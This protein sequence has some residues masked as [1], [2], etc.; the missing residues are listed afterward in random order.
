MSSA[1]PAWYALVSSAAPAASAVD[2]APPSRVAPPVADAWRCSRSLRRAP[3]SIPLLLLDAE[4]S[5]WQG[6]VWHARLAKRQYE[7]EAGAPFEHRR[8]ELR[9]AGTGNK[10]A[11]CLHAG[12]LH[13]GIG[14]KP[15]YAHTLAHKATGCL[16]R[17]VHVSIFSVEPATSP[18][19][20]AAAHTMPFSLQSRRAAGYLR[21]ESQ[22]HASPA[23]VC[24]A[25]SAGM[26]VHAHLGDGGAS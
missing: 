26:R 23:P 16:L 13:V 7:K 19:K 20:L 22:P 21:S 11:R 24:H 6:R 5:C 17:K 15:K 8:K 2:V 25:S 12:Y 9:A 4:G 14:I 18:D 10:S 1:A 3:R